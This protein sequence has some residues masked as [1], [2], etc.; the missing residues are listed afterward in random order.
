MKL[1]Y[2]K[3]NIASITVQCDICNQVDTLR[4]HFK[5]NN[6][7]ILLRT[8]PVIY[9]TKVDTR[10]THFNYHKCELYIRIFQ[11]LYDIRLTIS[12]GLV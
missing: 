2:F 7:Y 11:A 1:A 3:N 6:G 4:T 10:D 5:H 12:L 9:V 8:L